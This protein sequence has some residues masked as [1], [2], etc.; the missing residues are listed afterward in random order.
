MLALGILLILVAVALLIAAVF[1]GSSTGE[2]TGFDLG[3]V[4]V[5]TNTFGV[6]LTG[7]VTLLLLVAGLML[8]NA[9][10]RRARRRRQE[11]KELTRLTKKVEA[12]ESTAPAETTTSTTA[13]T[14][15]AE[16]AP[17]RETT[18]VDETKTTDVTDP[19]HPNR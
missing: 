1:G 14:G 6:F 9:G 3:P 11:R 2:P 17:T 15:T 16:T 4:N 5:E 13:T 19:D 8:I 7:A 10:L 18:A 12:Q